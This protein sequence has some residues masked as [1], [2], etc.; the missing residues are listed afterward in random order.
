MESIQERQGDVINYYENPSVSEAYKRWGVETGSIH[1]FFADKVEKFQP[2]HIREIFV[3]GQRETIGYIV[4]FIEGNTGGLEGKIVLDAGNGFGSMVKA[5][6]KRGAKYV[7]INIVPNQIKKAAEKAEKDGSVFVRANFALMP[8][9]NSSFDICLYVESL[10]HAHELGPQILETVRVLKSGGYMV[11]VEPML[12]VK[13]HELNNN[14]AQLVRN[15]EEGMA[16]NVTVSETL[17]GLAKA[18]GLKLIVEE[19]IIRYIIGSM[20]LAANSARA[21]KEQTPHRKAAIAYEQ[22]AIN[23]NLSYKLCVFRKN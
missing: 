2:E 22:L 8:F 12:K 16:L 10:T 7:G 17:I 20:Q 6:E 9:A 5:L 13:K 1:F 19:D 3:K 14:D 4:N 11:I 18:S 21:H 23:G 15:I